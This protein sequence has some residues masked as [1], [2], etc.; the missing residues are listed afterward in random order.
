MTAVEAAIMA[1][2]LFFKRFI[3]KLGFIIKAI[4]YKWQ[5]VN[6]TNLKKAGFNDKSDDYANKNAMR[7]INSSW[8]I[9]PHISYI[10]WPV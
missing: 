4:C 9:E 7:P 2:Y 10:V 3:N 5:I 6:E 1:M 8:E